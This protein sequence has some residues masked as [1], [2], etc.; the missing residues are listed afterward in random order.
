[1]WIR[2]NFQLWW[3]FS[4]ALKFVDSLERQDFSR[5]FRQLFARRPGKSLMRFNVEF[6]DSITLIEYLTKHVSRPL[7]QFLQPT[8]KYVGATSTYEACR[9]NHQLQVNFIT[10]AHPKNFAVYWIIFQTQRN[11]AATWEA[12]PWKDR[13][14]YRCN[15][16]ST[17]FSK[18][19]VQCSHGEIS[20]KKW[21][22]M[23]HP[24]Y[25]LSFIKPCITSGVQELNDPVFFKA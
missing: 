12:K 15:L 5:D 14:K 9:L 25:R 4:N 3:L 24:Q 21:N 22:S 23:L 11:V 20:S 10:S 8:N 6:Y 2:L 18:S 16:N 13:L 19:C 7:G 17:I 1:M